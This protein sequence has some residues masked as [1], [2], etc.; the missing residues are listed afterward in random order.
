M[1]NGMPVYSTVLQ[2]Q[3][4]CSRHLSDI[5]RF[6]LRAWEEK[7]A[8]TQT[9]AKDNGMDRYHGPLD[10]APRNASLFNKRLRKLKST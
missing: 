1:L 2:Q 10:T 4:S 5:G 9:P 3:F 6:D 7:K 8:F